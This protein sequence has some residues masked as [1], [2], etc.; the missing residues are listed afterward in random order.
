[1]GCTYIH[2]FIRGNSIPLQSP[3]QHLTNQRS[4]LNVLRP[5]KEV[6]ELIALHVERLTASRSARQKNINA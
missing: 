5:S 3:D 6:N 1:M 2:D 4:H